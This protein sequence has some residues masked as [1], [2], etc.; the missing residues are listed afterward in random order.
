VALSDL[1][2]ELVE[3]QTGPAEAGCRVVYLPE[4]FDAATVNI[5]VAGAYTLLSK[6]KNQE[7]D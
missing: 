4:K 3:V 7:E 5:V 1:E 2:F 6:M